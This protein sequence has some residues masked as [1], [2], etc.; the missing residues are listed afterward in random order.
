M[1]MVS[2][3]VCLKNHTHTH[4]NLLLAY[5]KNWRKLLLLGNGFVR[6][7]KVVVLLLS[8][9]RDCLLCSLYLNLSENLGN[10]LTSMLF[11]KVLYCV[12]GMQLRNGTDSSEAF[13]TYI[14]FSPGQQLSLFFECSFSLQNVYSCIC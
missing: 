7:Q 10:S 9:W 1:V 2:S 5:Y 11:Q 3:I 12:M 6:K 14:F 4:T 8:F 13:F